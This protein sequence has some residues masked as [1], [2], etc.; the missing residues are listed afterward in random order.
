VAELGNQRIRTPLLLMGGIGLSLLSGW[1]MAQHGLTTHQS[2][3]KHPNRTISDQASLELISQQVAAHPRDW[4]WSVLLARTQLSQGDQEAAARTVKRLRSLHPNHPDVMT[5]SSLLALKTGQLRAAVDEVNQVF[6]QSS[7]KQRLAMG[8]L[9]ADLHRQA[10][11]PG[12]ARSTYALLIKE[13]PDSAAPLMALA[14]LERD[15]GEGDQALSLLRKAESLLGGGGS[16]DQRQLSS[17]R[18]SWALEAARNRAT[19]G[20]R[21]IR[22]GSQPKDQAVR[23]P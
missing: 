20:V 3:P 10:D 18:L 15:R 23:K 2:R 12:A 5:L 16:S 19:A 8:L 7:P 11:D 4:R 22:E 13:Y 14:L 1:V 9:L 17:T 21:M 6:Q